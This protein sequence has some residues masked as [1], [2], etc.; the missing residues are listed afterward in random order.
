M[1][2]S[3]KYGSPSYHIL[4]WHPPCSYMLHTCQPSYS[5]QRPQTPNHFEMSAHEHICPRQV[6]SCWHMHSAPPKKSEFGHTLS[7]CICR[8][9]SSEFYPYPHFTCP[10]AMAFQETTSQDGIFLKTVQASSM[11]PHFAYMSIK[12]LH[13]EFVGTHSSGWLLR[14]PT[15]HI[16]CKLLIP[17]KNV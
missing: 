1:G 7:C 5:P 10:N 17:W 6:Q 9:C 11:L 13:S 2:T 12:L 3:S 15:R 14:L 4:R 16:C 8:N